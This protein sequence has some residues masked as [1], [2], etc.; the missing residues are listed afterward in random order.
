MGTF[1]SMLLAESGESMLNVPSTPAL[2]G[3]QV[4][5]ANKLR[6]PLLNHPCSEP[7]CTRQGTTLPLFFKLLYL[8]TIQSSTSDS[9]FLDSEIVFSPSDSSSILPASTYT[10]Y[11]SSI[12]LKAV[13]GSG[14][15]F[16]LFDIGQV[17]ILIVGILTSAYSVLM[18]LVS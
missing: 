1:S 10:L 11:T 18:T 4:V 12:I 3:V 17:F 2:L 9:S 6:G 16:S 7:L 15:I 5:D 14:I 8:V 13:L